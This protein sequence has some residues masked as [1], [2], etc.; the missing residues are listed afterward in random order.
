[1]LRAER[2]G[3]GRPRRPGPRS[4]ARY[5]APPI[6]TSSVSCPHQTGDV[7]QAPVTDEL[8]VKRL[9]IAVGASIERSVEGGERAFPITGSQRL[10]SV[11]DAGFCTDG[12]HAQKASH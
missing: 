12:V 10:V 6:A 9:W 11:P 1:M 8:A 3:P 2:N 5:D 7:R 4:C